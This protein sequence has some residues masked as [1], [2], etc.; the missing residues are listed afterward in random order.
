M[1]TGIRWIQDLQTRNRKTVSILQFS[2]LTHSNIH[3]DLVSETTGEQG[4]RA[5]PMVSC[6]FGMPQGPW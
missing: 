1:L 5:N 2:V 4:S 6:E 3:E